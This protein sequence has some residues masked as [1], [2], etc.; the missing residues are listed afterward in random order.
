MFEQTQEKILKY[1]LPL[2]LSLLGIV[3][4]I[5]G[6]TQSNL[7]SNF[8]QVSKN[9]NYPKK[10]LVKEVGGGI[11][12]DVS[13]AVNK[14]GVYTIKSEA[15]VEDAIK[16]ASGFSNQASK[17]FIAKKLNLSQKLSDGQKIYIPTEGEEYNLVLGS[18]IGVGGS[19]LVGIN[20]STQAQLEGLPAVGSVTA[21]KIIASRPYSSLEEL[22]TKKVISR[23]TFEKI[24]DLISLD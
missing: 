24:K 7:F 22:K 12:V 19:G 17:E 5:G 6:L 11:K 15:R 1:K 23:S 4:T 10:S 14:P 21:G 13:G 16:A 3:L 8:N 9:Q 2:A 20:S 18:S